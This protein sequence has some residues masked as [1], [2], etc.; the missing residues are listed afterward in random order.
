M[1]TE[2]RV[3]KQ[4]AVATLSFVSPDQLHILS[5]PTLSQ[6]AEHLEQLI[7][8]PELRVL[9]LTG[10]GSRTFS[11]GADLKELA[12]LDAERAREYSE[13]GQKVAQAI[14][15]FP[16]VTIAAL[17]APVYGGGIE[18]SMAFDFRL[19]TPR[20]VIHYQAAKLG[21]LPGWGG[22]QRLP[23]LVGR[24]RAKAMMILCRPVRAEEAL[25]WGLV[26]AVSDGPDL[27]PLLAEWAQTLAQTDR[28]S[29]IQIKRALD[30]GAGGD[31]AG[32]RDAFAACFA[33][34]APQHLIRQ[35]LAKSP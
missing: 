8:D 33:A 29:S 3:T 1:S 7:Q 11:A 14:A 24:S 10:D 25:A 28:Q 6:L 30:L 19:A 18:L 35:W 26:D 34:G 13:F 32:E 2:I 4:G 12:E 17:Q 27:A 15:R 9:V 20:T 23:Q 31:F 22:T 16:L 5:R 21:L